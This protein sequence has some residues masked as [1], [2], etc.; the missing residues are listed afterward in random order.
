[1][2]GCERRDLV[3]GG[4]SASVWTQFK[5]PGMNSDQPAEQA[6]ARDEP[7]DA[8]APVTAS[9]EHSFDSCPG[10]PDQAME[11]PLVQAIVITPQN[12]ITQPAVIEAGSLDLDG[13][14]GPYRWTHGTAAHL[15]LKYTRSR[16]T[17][18][19]FCLEC[20]QIS[21]VHH[22]F[23]H[24]PSGGAPNTRV[25]TATRLQTAGLGVNVFPSCI[26]A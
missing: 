12:D 24:A 3:D 6:L 14:P 11:N 5:G 10:D 25:A 17:T 21:D 22:A 4:V 16:R 8:G 18:Q 23:S 1:M 9:L 13:P 15:E 2:Q 19:G 20:T 26:A 7:V